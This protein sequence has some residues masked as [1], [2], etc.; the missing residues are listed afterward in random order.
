MA[1]A[2]A[3]RT[4]RLCGRHRRRTPSGNSAKWHLG[5]ASLDYRDYVVRNER[6]FRP[7]EVDLLVGN[8]AKARQVLEWQPK[9]TFWEL[10]REM[11]QS[12]LVGIL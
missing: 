4:G 7:A 1:H 6:F 5:E 12:D 3:G 2:A 10:I 11:I 9:T 8:A